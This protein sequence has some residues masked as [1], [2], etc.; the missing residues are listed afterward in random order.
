MPSFLSNALTGNQPA[1]KKVTE[2]EAV[3]TK[4]I[5]AVYEGGILKPLEETH[6]PDH[7]RAKLKII[8]E[9]EGVLLQP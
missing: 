7:Q 2:W 3:M 9:D 8:S 5:I 1:I 4:T 6:L